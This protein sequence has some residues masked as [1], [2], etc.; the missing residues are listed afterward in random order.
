MVLV[1]LKVLERG[2]VTGFQDGLCWCF[3]CACFIS[4]RSVIILRI[5]CIPVSR[6]IYSSKCLCTFCYNFVIP[7]CVE[8]LVAQVSI[9]CFVSST[10]VRKVC[11]QSHSYLM[12]CRDIMFLGLLKEF[13]IAGLQLREPIIR[14]VRDKVSSDGLLLL[15]ET[16][17]YI[18]ICHH[19]IKTSLKQEK[20]ED[21]V[22]LKI[23]YNFLQKQKLSLMASTS[24]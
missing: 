21:C 4:K 17:S 23:W 2:I 13:W 5:S 11:V 16:S 10:P 3:T 12:C 14:V 22:Q 1:Q 9:L 18:D 24:S 15:G 19:C 8:H 7:V 20:K 6:P